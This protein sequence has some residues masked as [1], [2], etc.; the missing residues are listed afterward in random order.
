MLI[1][2]IRR[3]MRRADGRFFLAAFTALAALVVALVTGSG[4]ILQGQGQRGAPGAA[5][6]GARGGAARGAAIPPAPGPK[7][8]IPDAKL[9]RSCESLTSV[10]L[11][12]TTIESSAPDPNN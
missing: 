9:V 4:H 11:Q 8:I 7:P 5:P 2:Q 1:T 6:A 10:T 12:N 3:L